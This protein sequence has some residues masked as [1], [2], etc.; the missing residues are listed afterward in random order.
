[1]TSKNIT[2][3]QIYDLFAIRIVFESKPDKSER[4]QCWDIYSLISED[5]PS[6]LDRLRDWVSNPKSNGYEALHCTLMSPQGNWVEV[7][8][9]SVRMNDIAE[10]GVA[11]H[12]YYKGIGKSDSDMDKWLNRIKEVLQNPNTNALEFLDQF[13]AGLVSSEIFVF[14]PKGRSVRMTKGATALDFA[15][16]IHSEI[17]NKA[18]AA[19]VNLKLVSLSYVLRNGDQ[20]E[21]ITAESQRPKREWLNFAVTSKAKNYIYMALKSDIKNAMK[22]GQSTLKKKLNELGV[23]LQSRVINKLDT[24]Y[25]LNNREEL[26]TKIGT[27]LIDLSDLDSVL[28]KNS[29]TK[30]VKFWKLQFFNSDKNKGNEIPAHSIDIGKDYLLT[31]NSLNK[32]LSYKIAECCNP[33]P[34]DPITGFIGDNGQVIIHKRS[35]PVAMKLGSNE[36]SK[37]INAKWTKHTVLSFLASIELKGIDRIGIVNDITKYITLALSVNIRKIFFETHD[38][39]FSGYLELYV[40]NT[41]DLELLMKR[42]QKIN[43]VKSVIRG[44]IKENEK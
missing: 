23:K 21:I 20:V 43:G 39:I 25:N 9:R 16:E 22:E 1:M 3:D 29:A 36:G 42:I 32:T 2:F 38:G 10:K 11:A 24:Y 18:I 4:M 5:Y 12:W 34:G 6:K 13:H 44:D 17:G 35:C 37:I 33:I 8:I 7:Q 30:F 41:E 19:K 14:T 40:H 28:K 27:G 31:E 26:Y 15:Y